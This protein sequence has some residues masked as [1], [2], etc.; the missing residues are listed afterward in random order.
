L[1]SAETSVDD[2]INAAL[3]GNQLSAPSD[4]LLA[5]KTKMGLLE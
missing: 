1:A 4:K 5:L 3:T 2:E